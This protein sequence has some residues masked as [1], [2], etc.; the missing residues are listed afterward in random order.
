MRLW[1]TPLGR[2]LLLGVALGTAGAVFG[3][4]VG[5][6]RD[7]DLTTSAAWG[8]YIAGGLLLFFGATPL[9]WAPPATVLVTFP[10]GSKEHVMQG[11]R[12]RIARAPWALLNFVVAAA[13]IGVG[14]LLEIYG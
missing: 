13:L 6:F 8:L 1:R 9:R 11:Q 7:A 3:L 2:A 14:A 12:D 4:A 5:A 10:E